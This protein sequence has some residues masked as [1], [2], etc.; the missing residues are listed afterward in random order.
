MVCMLLCVEYTYGRICISI[1]IIY[2]LHIDLAMHIL[3][4]KLPGTCLVPA[5]CAPRYALLPYLLHVATMC[6]MHGGYNGTRTNSIHSHMRTSFHL[7]HRHCCL[8][9]CHRCFHYCCRHLIIVIAISLL[10]LQYHCCHCHVLVVFT[11]ALLHSSFSCHFVI[12][13]CM[14]P[15]IVLIVA[16]TSIIG[17]VAMSWLLPF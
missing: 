9:C 2:V 16:V 15:F 17:S 8:C 6:T 4:P 5:L 14:S 1:F 11:I 3:V 7:F 10:S 13:T 12:V